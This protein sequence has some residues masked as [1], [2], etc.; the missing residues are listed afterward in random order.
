MNFG[1][2]WFRAQ[3]NSDLEPTAALL[4]Q[5]EHKAGFNGKLF[6][7]PLLSF[8]PW[9]AVSSKDKI[10]TPITI[11]HRLR[12][13]AQP[14]RLR[15]KGTPNNFLR[16]RPYVSRVPWHTG[17]RD[18]CCYCHDIG[19]D[20]HDQAELLKADLAFLECLEKPNMSTKGDALVALLYK[21]MCTTGLR[22]LL[23]P[24]RTHLLKL[25]SGQPSIQFG[26]LSNVRWRG[27]SFQKTCNGS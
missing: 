1:F 4:E 12:R 17:A 22:N 27:W 18:F 16:F 7:L 9:V 23:I 19:Y 2:L 3:S 24:Y 10:R 8:L 21:T 11:N 6:G 25:T 14:H 15:E 20:T 13:R 26:W 5:P